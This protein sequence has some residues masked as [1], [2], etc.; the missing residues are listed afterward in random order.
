MKEHE[1][2]VLGI[3]AAVAGIVCFMIAAAYGI[4]IGNL[5]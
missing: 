5:K 1:L 4:D 2:A 3:I